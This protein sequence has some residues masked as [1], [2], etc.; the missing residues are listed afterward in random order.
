MEE[1]IDRAGIALEIADQLLVLAAL[2]ECREADLPIEFHGFRHRAD[3]QR[4]GPQFIERHQIPPVYNRVICSDW[5]NTPH[6]PAFGP[7]TQPPRPVRGSRL[8]R[9]TA[10]AE[11]T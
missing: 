1:L 5:R 6:R 10:P 4:V 8:R 2:L 7:P 3:P 11:G 9:A